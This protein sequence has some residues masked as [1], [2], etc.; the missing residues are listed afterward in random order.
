MPTNVRSV[1]LNQLSAESALAALDELHTE[2]V[3]G[4][5]APYQYLVLMWALSRAVKGDISPVPYDVA[6]QD[7]GPILREF[8][9]TGSRPSVAMPWAALRHSPW[10]TVPVMIRSKIEVPKA[11]TKAGLSPQIIDII[12]HDSTFAARA[13]Q[14][15]R[16]ILVGSDVREAQIDRLITD[17]GIDSLPAYRFIPVEVN[18]AADFAADYESLSLED[19]SR[20]EAELQNAYL[21]HLEGQGHTVNS[22]AIPVEGG[23]LKVD[24]YDRDDDNLIEVKSAVDRGMIRLGLGQILDYAQ[25]VKPKKRT[26]LLPAIPDAD[27]V[28]LLNHHGVDV[29]YRTL[30]GTFRSP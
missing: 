18:T 22:I 10:W 11:N 9:L 6:Q 17:L 12:Q 30:D 15:I 1:A 20:R 4:R 14:R 7:L 28:I 13:V 8:A 27:L 16:A 25:F 3:N 19:R 23:T 21:A 5:R 26:L 24:L 29:V 2:T